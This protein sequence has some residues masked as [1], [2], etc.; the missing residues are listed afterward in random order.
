MSKKSN[1]CN[2]FGESLNQCDSASSHASNLR[3]HSKIH[4]GKKS[5]KCNKCNY[6]SSEK[7]DLKKHFKIYNGKKMQ[8]T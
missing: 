6:A 1:K 8:A 3:T 4:T 7:G 2:Q 5:N